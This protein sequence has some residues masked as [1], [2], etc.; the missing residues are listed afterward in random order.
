V[1]LHAQSWRPEREEQFIERLRARYQDQGFDFIVRPES[2]TLPDFLRSY[3]P[4]ALAQKPGL[5]VAI[6]VKN[7]QSSSAERALKDIR[8][9]FDGHPDWQ[10]HVY[11][12][13]DPLQRVSIP[14]ASPAAVRTRI[15]EVRALMS[16]GH[17]RPAFVM[18]WSL[19]EAA[20][21]ARDAEAT[22]SART[23]GTVVQTLAMSGLIE[24]DLERR[25]RGLIDLR[26]QIVHGD[27]AIEPSI[28][29]VELVLSAVEDAL[30]PEAA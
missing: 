16:Q 6:E 29:D 21:R 9:L 17:H 28:A 13:G 25:L 27:I 10:F 24:P 12:M 5:N 1:T 19:L 23:P 2:A 11:F 4:D 3:T 20:L 8:Q 15:N 30:S 26:N 22:S 14:A 18:A 7:R